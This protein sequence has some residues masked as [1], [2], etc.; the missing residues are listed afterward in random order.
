MILAAELMLRSFA[1]RRRR[2]QIKSVFGR[3]MRVAENSS[4]P[5]NVRAVY[6]APAKP[7]RSGF[8][9]E[10]RNKEAHAVF[11]VRRKRGEA[12]FATTRAAAGCIPSQKCLHF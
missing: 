9:G 5:A 12:D 6:G 7:Q 1:A 11:T 8:R 3:D 4:Q 10:R 2:N